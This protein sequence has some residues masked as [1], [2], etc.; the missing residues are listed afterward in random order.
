MM[1]SRD[2]AKWEEMWA[3]YDEQTYLRALGFVPAG[4]TVLDFRI[5]TG[6]LR[7]DVS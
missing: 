3:P 1:T 2:G 7:V 4:V 6:G 5:D